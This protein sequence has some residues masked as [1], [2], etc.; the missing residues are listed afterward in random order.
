MLLFV[1]TVSPI[2][3]FIAV[4]LMISLIVN[5]LEYICYKMKV[6]TDFRVRVKI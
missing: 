2:R 4:Y 5:I 3:I 1:E 6:W